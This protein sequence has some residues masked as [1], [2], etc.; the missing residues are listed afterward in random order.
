MDIFSIINTLVKRGVKIGRL[1]N[2]IKE[3]LFASFRVWKFF[4]KSEDDL[5]LVL[6]QQSTV[7]TDR[8]NY[9]Q[10]N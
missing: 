1:L 9:V 4:D 3:I 10:R 6:D 7:L 2:K 8:I 5:P